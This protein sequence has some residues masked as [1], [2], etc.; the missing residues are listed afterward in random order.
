MADTAKSLAGTSST[1]SDSFLVMLFSSP[2]DSYV[3]ISI[4]LFAVY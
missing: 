4:T 1:T 3:Q 2:F